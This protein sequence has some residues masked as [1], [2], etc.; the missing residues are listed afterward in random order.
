MV[1]H[2]AVNRRVAGSSPARGAVRLAPS[3]PGDG[4]LLFLSR[5]QPADSSQKIV[6]GSQRSVEE[7]PSFFALSALQRPWSIFPISEQVSRV[8]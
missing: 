2:A 4:A 5:Q 6:V 7:G 8:F 1:E 3:P